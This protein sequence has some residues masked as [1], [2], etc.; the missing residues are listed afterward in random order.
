MVDVF[1]A[2]ERD[3]GA[4]EEFGN[5]L[6]AREAR[7]DVAVAV[8]KNKNSLQRGALRECEASFT[9][10]RSAVHE[11]LLG[12]VAGLEFASRAFTNNDAVVAEDF[13]FVER[14]PKASGRALPCSG[15]A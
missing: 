11:D 9:M 7:D 8:F 12:V 5:H 4:R 6:A 1:V 3:E 2:M 10:P 13:N 14:S 15:V